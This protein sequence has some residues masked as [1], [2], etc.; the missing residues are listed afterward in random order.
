MRRLHIDIETYSSVDIKACGLYRYVESPDFQILLLTYAY[1]GKAP[2]TIDL[3]STFDG[4][5]IP[6]FLEKDIYDPTIVKV[7]HNATF[8]RVCLSK[9]FG[10]PIPVSQW[11][12][13][14]IKAAY[15][16]LPLGLDAV[17]EALKLNVRKDTE[18]KALIKYF[19]APCKPTRT[20][21]G[22]TRN[23]PEDDPAR[24]EKY[25]AYNNQDVVVEREIDEVLS[26]V[27]WPSSERI[28]YNIDAVINDRGIG[29]DRELAE[30]ATTLD[31]AHK[32]VLSARIAELTGLDNPNSAAQMKAWLTEEMGEEVSS[33]NKDF[34]KDLIQQAAGSPAEGVLRL[35]QQLAKSSTAKYTSML[36][37]RCEDGR[38]RGLFQFYGAN[39][40]GRFAGRLIQL[41]NLPQNHIEPLALARQ[42]IREGDG[43][44]A[45]AFFGNL[46]S[47]LSQLIR[48]AFIPREG[49]VLAVAD[50]SA[51]E[52]RVLA[53]LAQEQWRMDVFATTGK[54]YE[55]SAEMMFHQPKG[56][57]DKSS[58]L[59]QR[60]KVAELA[61]GYGGGVNALTT[62][63]KDGSI[64]EDEKQ[65][66]VDAWRAASPAIVALWKDLERC[67]FGAV[68][69]GGVWT[70][71][72]H[73]IEFRVEGK[74][75]T[76]KLPNGRK[77]Y[78]CEPEFTTNRFGSRSIKYKAMDQTTHKWGWTE[79]YSGKFCE[80]LCQA[81][82]RDCLCD[83]MLKIENAGLPIVLH[84]HDEAAVEVPTENAEAALKTMLGIMA[85]P[86]PWAPGLL[87]KGEGFI[88]EYYKKD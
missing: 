78:Y 31:E 85:E 81:I 77:L 55:A 73:G 4:E 62:M 84:V 10:K 33:L 38:A 32:A 26:L 79:T 37:C 53:W 39:R 35:R 66:I 54:I 5:T 36:N 49:H 69:R 64:P 74:W 76:I 45:E 86:L 27:E 23:L 48:T 7:A 2:V 22:R 11:E 42:L 56:S 46:S 70:T 28:N 80:N 57:V 20:N 51:I 21:G 68:G 13:T 16:G 14:M 58:P 12:C 59:R 15:C 41:Q 25:K 9:H 65:G 34:M 52:A 67:S 61:L 63:D 44:A 17:A 60:G 3:A 29:I 88:T 47:T 72:N 1:D 8:E 30:S 6:A 50:F 43:A 82:A 71:K 40:T 18:G 75:L 24:W 19:S 83:A 87:L